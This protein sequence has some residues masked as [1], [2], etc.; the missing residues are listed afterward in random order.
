LQ[1]NAVQD[2]AYTAQTI[3]YSYDQLVRLRE[4]R[5]L[6]GLRTSAPDADLLRREQFDFDRSGNRTQQSIALN[7]G[8]PTVTNYT[9]NAANQ[10]ISDGTNSYT[11]DNN[12]NLVGYTW[13]RANRM[14]AIS[15][16][17]Y[18][19]DG[20]GTRLSETTS[21]YVK[22]YLNDLQPGLPVVL[23]ATQGVNTE[24]YVYGP[25]GIQAQQTSGQW[26]WATQD[27]LGSVRGVVD[28]S[29]DVR[30]MRNYSAYG[31]LV[32]GLSGVGQLHGFT[33][34]P[35][36]IDGSIHLRA[37]TYAPSLGIFVSEDL[38]ETANRYAYVSGNPTNFVDSS[39]LLPCDTTSGQQDPACLQRIIGR[40]QTFANNAELMGIFAPASGGS[41]LSYVLWHYLGGG[42]ST[43]YLSY[44][45]L[46]PA[47]LVATGDYIH[48]TLVQTD[49][50]R[51]LCLGGCCSLSTSASLGSLVDGRE[52]RGERYIQPPAWF[53][54]LPGPAKEALI[55]SDGTVINLYYGVFGG[56]AANSAGPTVANLVSSN[57]SQ[58]VVDVI[59]PIEYYDYYDWF[60]GGCGAGGI[61]TG[62]HPQS[63]RVGHFVA[64]EKADLAHPFNWYA[65][66]NVTL[67]YTISCGTGQP[68]ILQRTVEASPGIPLQNRIQPPCFSPT[69]WNSPNFVDNWTPSLTSALEA[70]TVLDPLFPTDFEMDDQGRILVP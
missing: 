64:L 63:M 22:T 12:G 13:D 33:G 38:L 31:Q 45:Y 68:I 7:G 15:D 32:D 37:R 42:G 26:Y 41:V 24:R 62:T 2:K 50:F 44:N 66:V 28:N 17:T 36:N 6:P 8:A 46:E 54:T 4:A 39:G 61:A 60:F 53:E 19:Y 18:A 48:D 10:M 25:H 3:R 47:S 67:R 5:T 40:L 65:Y 21:Q 43:Q 49:F 11:Y 59:T 16:V 58:A 30:N 27:G 57:G 55:Q 56:I 70:S 52:V 20:L 14:I 29:G 1:R 23:G 9:Y 51:N 69:R 35:T 34:E